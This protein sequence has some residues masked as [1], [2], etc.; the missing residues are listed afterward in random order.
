[1]AFNQVLIRE[2]NANLM[3]MWIEK[4][5][6]EC[7]PNMTGILLRHYAISRKVSVSIPDV[8]GFFI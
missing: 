2:L 3:G 6:K 5:L 1:M 7:N 8:V 4:Q